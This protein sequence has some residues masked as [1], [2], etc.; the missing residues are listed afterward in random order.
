MFEDAPTKLQKGLVDAEDEDTLMAQFSS[1]EEVWN[2]RETAATNAKLQ[3]Y[4]WFSLHCYDVVKVSMLRQRRELAGLGS[5]PSPYYTNGVESINNLLKICMGFKKQDLATFVTKLKDLVDTQFSEEDRA[6]AGV[7]EYM[8]DSKYPKFH[9][10]AAVWCSMSTDQRQKV[11]KRFRSVPP[12][13]ITSISV[14]S[15]LTDQLPKEG[16]DSPSS[17][18]NPLRAL[19]ITDY[20]AEQIWTHATT[21]LADD[22]NFSVAPSSNK[23]AWMVFRNKGLRPHFV[24]QKKGHYECDQDCFYFQMCKICAHIVS[25]ANRNGDLPKFIEWFK[26]QN[27][28]VNATAIAQ[29]GIPLSSVGKKGGK[30]K[31]V[32][33]NT[34]H[35][36]N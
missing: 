15:F 9:F 20:A 18:S 8:I 31:G 17:C 29:A 6:V 14:S 5:P 33:K 30:R 16:C 28:G 24:H 32:S 27:H 36:N 4:H 22:S 19:C 2:N 10:T 13:A 35:K 34:S 1:L 25:I 11:M 23:S 21:L 7:G 12:V 26:K 3:F